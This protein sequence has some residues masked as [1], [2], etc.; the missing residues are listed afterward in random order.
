VAATDFRPAL[1]DDHAYRA[2]RIDLDSVQSL[3]AN[4]DRGLIQ[5]HLHAAGIGHPQDQVS[6]VKLQGR[7]FL[8]KLREE[9]IGLSGNPDEVSIPQLHFDPRIGV[10]HDPVAADQGKIERHLVPVHVA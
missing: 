1:V 8:G 2:V 10:A 3:F 4:L 5:V 7:L 6:L 9:D